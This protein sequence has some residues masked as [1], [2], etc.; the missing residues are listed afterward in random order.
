[1]KNQRIRLGLV[2][3]ASPSEVGA[4][5][6]HALLERLQGTLSGPEFS[7]LNLFPYQTPVTDVQRAIQAGRHF[8]DERVHA[9]C[10]VAAS[11]FEDYLVLDILEECDVPTILWATPGM[12]TGSLCGTQQL[13]FLLRQLD[14][15]Y[16]LLYDELEKKSA[17]Q[18]LLEY[19]SAAA[20]RYYL[21]RARIGSLGHRVE[22]MTETTGHELAIKKLFGPRIVSIDSQLFMGK[23]EEVQKE[24]VIGKWEELKSQVGN[25][26][27][28]DEDGIE[29]LRVH[30]VLKAV[31]EEERLDALAVGC[32]PNFMG[33]FCLAASLLGEEGIPVACE[34]DLN[35]AL[36]MLILIWLSGQPTHNTDLLNPIEEDN[37]IVFSHCGSGSFSLANNL[38][39]VTL[40][41]VRLMDKGLCCLFTARPGTVTLVNIVPTIDGYK[42]GVMEGKAVET[43]MVFPGNPL[44]VHFY[45]DYKK[46]LNWIAD[47]GL[48]HHWI[49]AYGD[50]RNQLTDFARMTRCQLTLLE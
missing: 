33:K 7:K 31:I 32:Y 8:Y 46:V 30:T 49:A 50:L 34:G 45:L 13:G 42:M 44:R 25:V 47:E 21:R 27:C 24:S 41:P 6:A 35:G 17:R 14:K 40:A 36:G 15:P 10:V 16:K 4:D 12:E 38:S 5:Q 11:W 3:V 37:T 28:G 18:S 20:L 9:I 2:A 26:R 22:G 29:S 23:V 48:G 43:E 39:E 19:T 1:M